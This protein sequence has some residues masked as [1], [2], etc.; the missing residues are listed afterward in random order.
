MLRKGSD[1]SEESMEKSWGKELANESS[2]MFITHFDGSFVEFVQPCFC[3]SNSEEFVNVFMRIGFGSTIKMVFLDE[4]QVV[5]FNG[6]FVCGF[7]NYDCGTGSRSHNTVDSLHGFIIHRIEVLKGNEK[8]MEVI[9][10]KNWQIDNSR[11]LRR[12]DSLIEWNSSVSST[13]SSIQSK[14]KFR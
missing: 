13:K 9:D 7:K 12:I 4:S 8:V 1:L 5:T 10:V 6:K 3:F 11:M 14:F 2:L